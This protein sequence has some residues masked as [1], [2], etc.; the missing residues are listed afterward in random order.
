MLINNLKKYIFVKNLNEKIKKNIKKLYNAK[1]IYTSTNFNNE[2][3]AKC[4]EL[5][6]FCSKNNIPL[7]IINNFKVALKIKANGIFI[8]S[9]NKR[10]VYNEFL[11]KKFH[12]IGS[13]HNQLEYYFKKKQYCETIA[14]SPLF[15]NPKYSKNKTLGPIRFNLISKDWKTELCALGG[16]NKNNINN[17][18]NTKIS[19]IS[20]LRFIEDM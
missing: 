14:L 16:I 4:F 20:F 19:A 5:K 17:I 6:K 18:K 7:Y 10:L 12:I 8:S 11:R 13:A 15:L 1:V 9:N 2:S 3:I